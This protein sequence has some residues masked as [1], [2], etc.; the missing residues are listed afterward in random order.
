MFAILDVTDPEPLPA[1]SPLRRLARVMMTPHIA[2]SMGTEIGR[3]TD[4]VL[5][6]GPPHRSPP[7][8]AFGQSPT[9]TARSSRAWS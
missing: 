4:P 6:S 7:S 1:D 8:C 5:Y 3:L 2:G 9:W